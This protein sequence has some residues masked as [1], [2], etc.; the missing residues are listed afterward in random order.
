MSIDWDSQTRRIKE[1]KDSRGLRPKD[2]DIL[3][4]GNILE[5]KDFDDEYERKDGT[6]RKVPRFKYVFPEGKELVIPVTLHEKITLI[7]NEASVKP[8]QIRVIVSGEGKKT[9]YDALAL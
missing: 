7:M 6:I 8:K 4:M 1:I 9:K 3:E 5:I 2:R